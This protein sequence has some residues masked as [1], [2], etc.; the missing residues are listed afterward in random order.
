MRNQ[1]R[2]KRY[3]ASLQQ[4]PSV[5][6]DSSPGNGR[7]EGFPKRDEMDIHAACGQLKPNQ[8]LVQSSA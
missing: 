4:L 1:P 8:T 2:T 7:R 3:P 5:H 6:G